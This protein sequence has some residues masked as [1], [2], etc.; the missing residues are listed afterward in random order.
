MVF[1]NILVPLDGSALAE[2]VIPHVLGIAR[3]LGSSIILLRVLEP[4]TPSAAPPDPLRWQIQR[5]EADL[6]LQ[7][8][9]ERVRGALGEPASPCATAPV[10]ATP[11]EAPSAEE[12]AALPGEAPAQAWPAPDSAPQEHPPSRVR[13]LLLEGR[14][15]ETIVEVCASEQIDLVVLGTHGAG[16]LSRWALSSVAQKVLRAAY[17]PVFIVRSY[18]PIGDAPEVSYRRIAV[19]LDG[20]RRAESALPAAVSLAQ[21]AGAELVLLSVIRRPEFP[22]AGPLTGELEELVD[23][24]MVELHRAYEAYLSTVS[25]RL[26]VSTRTCV[27]EEPS[28]IAALQDL[29]EAQQIDLVVLCAHGHASRGTHPYGAFARYA[30]ED[31]TMP[32]LIMQDIPRSLVVPTEAERAAESTRSR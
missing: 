10:A 12:R 21:A 2:R 9:V 18:K 4:E 15:A 17:L 26:T 27:V 29:C 32:L 16:G 14:A 5:A 7:A 19:P 30:I 6:H 1:K 23:R 31:G 24:L 8:L 25:Q 22:D 13:R 20:S 28:I 3:P 11:A